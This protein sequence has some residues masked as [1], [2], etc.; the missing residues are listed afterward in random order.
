MLPQMRMPFSYT[1]IAGDAACS[2]QKACKVSVLIVAVVCYPHLF[3]TSLRLPYTCT[4]H[5]HAHA[6]IDRDHWRRHLLR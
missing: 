2:A 5:A 4:I 1:T 3:D 6:L